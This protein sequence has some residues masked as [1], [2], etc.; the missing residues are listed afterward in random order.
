MPIS[1]APYKRSY[2]H[3]KSRGSENAVLCTYCKRRVPR[4]KAF[5]K[6]KGFRINDPT[7][8]RQIPRYQIHTFSQKVYVCPSCARS[9]QIVQP[10]KSDRKHHLDI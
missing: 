9:R 5:V 3:T 2:S 4:W 10:G 7:L 1:T 6:F 8:M